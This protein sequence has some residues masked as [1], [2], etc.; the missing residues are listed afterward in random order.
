LDSWRAQLRFRQVRKPRRCR[1]SPR[2]NL[3]I[4]KA[5]NPQSFR[6][7]TSIASSRKRYAGAIIMGTGIGTAIMAGAT[8]IGIAV[9]IIV[10]GAAATDEDCA[11]GRDFPPSF[12]VQKVKQNPA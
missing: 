9:G 4:A 7:Q 6:K 5:L 11:R 10:T 12:L 3:P 2:R 8:A 1:P